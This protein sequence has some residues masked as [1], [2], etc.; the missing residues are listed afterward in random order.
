[1]SPRPYFF[2]T[3][4]LCGLFVYYR[5]LLCHAVI[6]RLLVFGGLLFGLGLV[7]LLRCGSK[8]LLLFESFLFGFHCFSS[9]S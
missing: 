5:C 1:M 3:A 2:Q 4:F 6:V 7:L 8:L 9:L